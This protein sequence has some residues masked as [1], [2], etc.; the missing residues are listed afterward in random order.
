MDVGV[1][2]PNTVPGATGRQLTDWARVAEEAGFSCL[3]TIDRVVYANYEPFVA[4]SAAAAVTERIRLATTVM[5]GPLRPNPAMIAKQAL[6]LDALGGGGRVV[7][8][9][10]AGGREDDFEASGVSMSDRGSWLDAALPRI[11]EVWE[12]RSDTDA[13][14]GPRPQGDGPT[15]I[16]GGHADAS[17]ERAGRYGAGWIMGGLPPT[18]F[19]A[20]A[21]K[22]D[23]AWDRNG[24]DGSPHKMA[25]AYFA[26]GDDAEP[27]AERSLLDYYAFLGD[28][29]SA[30]IV[31]GA[32]KD[33]DAVRTYQ[34]AFEEA[35]C[36]ELVWIPCSSD[37]GQVGLLAEA[38]GLS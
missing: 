7:L 34:S 8:G 25:L 1:G 33:A 32:A 27:T 4:L 18:M 35:G 17:F 37:V 5:I 6:A 31:A 15:L 38:A 36:D 21:A 2:L 26:L 9:I 28:E 20:F 3:G 10:G 13:R 22:V 23:E 12:G 14:I 29:M 30:G 24:R 11:L 16:I 19:G